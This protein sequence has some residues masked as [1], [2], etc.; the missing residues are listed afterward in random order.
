MN[1]NKKLS[2]LTLILLA[3]VAFTLSLS[4]G[5]SER[6]SAQAPEVNVSELALEIDQV[7]AAELKLKGQAQR[8]QID[9]FTFCRRIYLDAIGRIPTIGELDRFI[10]DARSDKRARLI[11]KLLHSKGYNS[12]WYNYW[13]DLLRVKDIGDKLHH[14]GN[15]SEWIKESVRSNKPYDQMAYELVNASGDLYKPGNGATGFYAREPMPLDHLANSVKTFLGMSIECAQC[16][17]HPYEDWT[18]QDFYQLAAFTSKTHLR[19]EPLREEEAKLYAKHRAILKNRDFDEWIVYRESIRVKHAAIYGNGTGYMRLPHD[20]QYK[21]GEPH[22]VMDANVLFGDMPEVSYKV[23]KEKLQSMSKKQFGPEI[24]ARSAMADWMTSPDNPMF[25]K[26]TV[27]RLWHSIMGS[28]LVGQLGG[29]T[30]EEMGAHPALTEK[31]IS[32]MQVSQYDTKLF[33]SALFNSRAY[34][35]QALAL[36]TTPPPYILDGPIVRRLPAEVLVDSFLSLKTPTP[37][38]YV[39]TKFRWDGFTHF[40]DKSKDMTAKDFVDYSVSGPGRQEFQNREEREAM[41]RNGQM[42]PKALWRVSTFGRNYKN[43]WLAMLMGKSNRELIDDATLEP[44]IPQ[45]LFMMNGLEAPEDTL[46]KRKLSQATTKP[47]KMTTLWKA[48]LSRMPKESE[49]VLFENEPDDIL[50]ALINSN[51]FRFSK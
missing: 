39:A 16:H 25:T 47:E 34:Q 30:Q 12:H 13:A 15:Y 37:D 20:Y 27:N 1:F 24:G 49:K 2:I 40:Y 44:N 28:E 43:H 33:L 6:Q 26:A 10:A 17:N 5:E 3:A 21:D 41:K 22:Q 45:I 23:S 4:A 18:Q 8:P 9:D 11:D 48:I 29:L 35:S 36:T 46:I 14:S 42:G 31:L 38:K 19:V 32:I 50:W 7:V 51:E